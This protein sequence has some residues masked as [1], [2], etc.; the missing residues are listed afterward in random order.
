MSNT[1]SKSRIGQT[2]L[3]FEIEIT[4]EDEHAV[5]TPLDPTGATTIQIEFFGPNNIHFK[6]VA[7][8]SFVTP[9]W[10]LT[11]TDPN[12]SSILTKAGKWKMGY[13]LVMAD[14]KIKKA[15]MFVQFEVVH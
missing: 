7:V 4:E 1:V 6:K 10:F 9:K 5:Q 12:T 14:S 8:S 11:Y 3:P 13:Y 2:G 15:S